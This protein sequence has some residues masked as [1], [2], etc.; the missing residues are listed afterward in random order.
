MTLKVVI[1]NVLSSVGRPLH[2]KKITSIIEEDG[3]YQNSVAKNLAASVNSLI[4]RDLKR[5]GEN[6]KFKCFGRGT[7]G[8]SS[9]NETDSARI[10]NISKSS[11]ILNGVKRVLLDV[12]RPLKYKEITKLM[13]ERG[14]FPNE[15]TN[16]PAGSVGKRIRDDINKF[17]EN[18]NFQKFGPG[19][20]GLLGM[21]FPE[22][23]TTNN[24]KTFTNKISSKSS[25]ENNI[26]SAV[27]KVLEEYGNHN[28]MHYRDIAKKALSNGWL[29]KQKKSLSTLVNEE[30]ISDI[31]SSKD[32]DHI[33]RFYTKG[34][35]YFGLLKWSESD[36]ASLISD[37]NREIRKKLYTQLMK[38]SPKQFEKLVKML[39]TKMGFDSKTTKF[40]GDG[41]VDVRGILVISE[42]IRIKL[43]VQVKQL[44]SD[45]K[46]Q[47]KV[48]RE[49]RGALDNHEQGL[50]V[51]T[52]DF[53]LG[54]KD[55][56]KGTARKPV[57]LINGD[58]LLD[59]LIKFEIGVQRVK[60]ELH[61]LVDFPELD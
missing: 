55:D 30:L 56:A 52:S 50:I 13:L 16:D 8:L 4:T 51:T 18:S 42:V 39:L 1:C 49:L 9:K 53:S 2:Y 44:N 34:N 54:A 28:P 48:V 15:Q 26:L 45:N 61:E 47:V 32:G 10:S 24:N 23:V 21:Q 22:K 5:N 31:S 41:G 60:K 25:N 37:N 43:A 57:D 36:L 20:Y 12:G 40:S 38:L 19:I 27:E 59:L 3:L 58:K 17:G 33:S 14:L 7:Y 46:V 29:R 11:K 35:G 6:S